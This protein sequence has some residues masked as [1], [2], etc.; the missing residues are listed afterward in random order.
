M[1]TLAIHL[2]WT[3]YGTW[4][5]GDRRGHWSPLF[6]V[7]GHIRERGGKL[8]PGDTTTREVTAERMKEPAKRLSVVEELLVGES[9]AETCRGVLEPL[10]VAIEPT[11]IHLLIRGTVVPVGEAAGRLKSNSGSRL[12]R[13]PGNLGRERVWT[14]GYWKVFLFD[15]AAVSAVCSYIERHNTDRGLP[16]KRFAWVT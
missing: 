15:E 10:A 14:T 5:P 3:T 13:L 2:I 7:Y 1:N 12:L 11:H 8:N 16:A 9:I 4:L 6:D